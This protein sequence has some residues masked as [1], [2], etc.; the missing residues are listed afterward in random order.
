M[1]TAADKATLRGAENLVASVG[2]TLNVDGA[3]HP[4]PPG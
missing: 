1:E 4:A 2:L 3:R